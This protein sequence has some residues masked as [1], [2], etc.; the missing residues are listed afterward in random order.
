MKYINLLLLTLILVTATGCYGD[1]I[2]DYRISDSVFIED[3]ENPGL[4][5]YSE[6][7][8]NSFG[9]YWG[10]LPVS[11]G[12]GHE[13]STIEVND[14][15][16]HIRLFGAN[17]MNLYM[18]KLSL[19]GYAPET[20]SGLLDLNGKSFDLTDPDACTVTLQSSDI[21]SSDR[22]TYN[23]ERI[24]EGSFMVRRAQNL[25]VD[26]VLN[27]VVLSGTFSFKAIVDGSPATFLN[28]RFD[29]CFGDGNFF[30]LQ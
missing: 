9:F 14:G 11:T 25:Y 16:C 18:L 5:V 26:R 27:G 30:Y 24:L 23:L 12:Q 10:L 7:G 21:Y 20:F 1:R 2:S 29:M 17:G 15:I 3:G 19:P 8:Y 22:H 28:G 6:K 13:Q 4:P